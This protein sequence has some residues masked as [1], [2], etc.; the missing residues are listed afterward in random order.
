MDLY[1]PVS[2]CD[3]YAFVCVS[4]KVNVFVTSMEVHGA[5]V[6]FREILALYEGFFWGNGL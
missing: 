2:L 6:S 1:S 4:L 3:I 5:V